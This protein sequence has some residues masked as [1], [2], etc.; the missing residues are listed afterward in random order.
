MADGS[1]TR[2]F[3][4]QRRK[5]ILDIV[6]KHGRA[7]V[8]D[9]AE[10]LEISPLT[11]RRDLDWLEHNGDIYRR[12][13]EAL[14]AE[15]SNLTV[16]GE[17][18]SPFEAQ[19]E[20]I[21]QA[22]AS[23]VHDGD[24]LLINTSSTALMMIP[25]IKAR[26][27]TIVTNSLKVDDLPCPPEGQILVSGGEVRAPRGVLSGDFAL[28]NINAVTA[29]VGFTGCAGISTTAGVTSTTQQEAMVNSLMVERSEKLIVV[30]DSSKL[31]IAAGFTYAP[32]TSVALLI[33]DKGASDAEIDTLTDCG[34][35]DV[36]RV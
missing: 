23:L 12:Y 19:K 6:R 34:V 36:M 15:S 16:L 25:H 2:P 8:A 3:V 9:L 35:Q 18:A 24:L 33:T 4:E 10:T 1:K 27:V 22:A 28:H 29:M 30:A 13:G 32:L 17:Q 5:T 14:L 11:V 7:S 26:G 21:A 31:G 20:L